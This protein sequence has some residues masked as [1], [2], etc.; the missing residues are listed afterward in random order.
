[1]KLKIKNPNFNDNVEQLHEV[2]C[3]AGCRDTGVD[4]NIQLRD[5]DFDALFGIPEFNFEQTPQI[6][7]DREFAELSTEPWFSGNGDLRRYIERFQKGGYKTRGEH[8]NGTNMGMGYYFSTD[9]EAVKKHYGPVM[10]M[11]LAKDANIVFE[12]DLLKMLRTTFDFP[13]QDLRISRLDC[14]DTK[15]QVIMQSFVNTKNDQFKT[16][17]AA[18]CGY[19]GIMSDVCTPSCKVI[20]LG[21]RAK[22]IQPECGI[23]NDLY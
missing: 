20:V 13:N 12:S 4:L 15:K 9:E 19:D 7:T 3:K 5:E 1:V 16:L 11:K 21:N 14:P 17:M 23:F 22:A 8:K 10:T 18:L 6:V 2:L